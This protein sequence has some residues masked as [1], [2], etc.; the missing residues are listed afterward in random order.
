MALNMYLIHSSQ[1]AHNYIYMLITCYYFTLL[2]QSKH[3]F[4]VL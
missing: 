3:F 4:I 2:C 1:P